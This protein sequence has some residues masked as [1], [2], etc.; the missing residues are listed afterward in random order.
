M[1]SVNIIITAASSAGFGLLVWFI[2]ESRRAKET[3]AKTAN[4]MDRALLVLIRNQLISAHRTA[5]KTWEITTAEK[6]SFRE[7]HD[8]YITLGGN[9]PTSHLIDDLERVRLV[10]D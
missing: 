5:V 6:Q 4:A 9:G 7:M 2:Q 8:L 10:A 3:A 1:D